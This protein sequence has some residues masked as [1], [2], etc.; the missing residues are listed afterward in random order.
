MFRRSARAARAAAK[1]SIP[2]CGAASLAGIATINQNIVL[3]EMIET[4]DGVK[5]AREIAAL[6]G[7]TAN[8]AASGDLG[9]FRL[10]ARHS[11]LRAA[12]QHRS[13]RGDWRRQAAVW[14]VRMARPARFRLLPEGQ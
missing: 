10:Q 12:D 6:P 11:R 8:F 4:L 2:I 9:N 1:P 13:R 3:I 5:D 14:S 7:V